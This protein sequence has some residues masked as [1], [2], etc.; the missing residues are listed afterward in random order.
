MFVQNRRWRALLI[1]ISVLVLS[2]IVVYF[3]VGKL[4]ADY[5]RTEQLRRHV[6]ILN[7]QAGSPTQY[8]LLSEWLVEG[9]K[10]IVT[11]LGIADPIVVSFLS[12]RVVQNIALFGIASTF[13]RRMG[14]RLEGTLAALAVA[15]WSMTHSLYDSDLSFNLYS[16]L[17]LYSIAGVIILRGWDIWII[18]LAG[19]AAINR[20][21]GGLIIGLFLLARFRRGQFWDRRTLLIASGAMLAF[22]VGYVGVRVGLGPREVILPHGRTPGLD[23]LA[24]NLLR[25]QTWVHLA[26]SWSVF[27]VIALLGI[28]GLPETLRRWLIWIPPIWLPVHFVLAVAAEV[29][30]MLMPQLIIFIPA[31]FLVIQ[32]YRQNG[33]VTNGSGVSGRADHLDPPADS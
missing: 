10:K 17:V 30:L 20:E 29:R 25:R 15:A 5:V 23:L 18:A 2:L 32:G 3:Q 13:Y 24:Y 31:A 7:G 26:A 21:T 22:L 4:W 14:L 6:E 12:F 19:V 1:A 27:P 9:W 33:E 8:R 16:D 28:K 11:S